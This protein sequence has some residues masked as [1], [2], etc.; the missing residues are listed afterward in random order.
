MRNR[1]VFFLIS[2]A[3]H[4]RSAVNTVDRMKTSE[5]ESLEN[6]P[7]PVPGVVLHTFSLVD[8][9]AEAGGCL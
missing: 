1:S 4:G 8:Q 7:Q 5:P 6:E 9:K 3:R 2:E